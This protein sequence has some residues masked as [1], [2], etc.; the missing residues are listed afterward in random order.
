MHRSVHCPVSLCIALKQ[1][2]RLYRPHKDCPLQL[3]YAYS[4]LYFIWM[5]CHTLN[6]FR[7]RILSLPNNSR[8]FM[9]HFAPFS[10]HI[11][12]IHTSNLRGTQSKGDDFTSRVSWLLWFPPW[13][14]HYNYK[15]C[16]MP[17]CQFYTRLP[18]N[19]LPLPFDNAVVISSLTLLCN[20]KS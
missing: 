20:S 9:P 13:C 11:L 19:P 2:H 15:L 4:E 14:F 16:Y 18:T 7:K 8:C 1:L 12:M 10:A 3:Q 17:V 6:F 5:H